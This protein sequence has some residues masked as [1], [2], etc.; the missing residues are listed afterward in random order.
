M[1][2]DQIVETAASLC[3]GGADKA[4]NAVGAN[5]SGILALFEAPPS[6]NRP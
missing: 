4:L 3:A 5:Q 6:G 2:E 1:S